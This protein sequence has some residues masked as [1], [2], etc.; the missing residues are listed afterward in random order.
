MINSEAIYR[1]AEQA[2]HKWGTRDPIRLARESGVEVIYTNDFKNLLGMYAYRWRKRAIILNNRMD[3]SLRVMVAAH[4]LGH[5]TFHRALAKDDCFKEFELFRMTNQTEYEANA[6]AAHIL[7]DTDECIG[8]ARR[9]CDVV[10]IA[11]TMHSE[12]NLMLIKIQELIRLGYE[13]RLPMS[14]QID[15]FKN[16]QV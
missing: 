15:F 14:P 1:K 5:D 11:K 3:D 6:Y 4:E 8:L 16:I 7:I 2:V 12:I 10:H 9:G 13:L